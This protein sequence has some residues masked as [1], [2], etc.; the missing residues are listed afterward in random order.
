VAVG[1]ARAYSRAASIA[2]LRAELAALGIP[3]RVAAA[4]ADEAVRDAMRASRIARIYADRW[5]S[6][7]EADG[8]AEASRATVG[9]VRVIAATESAE[10]WNSGRLHALQNYPEIQVMRVWDATLDKRTCQVCANADGD[11]VGVQ[12]RFP[13]GEPGM[14]HPNCRCTWHPIPIQFTR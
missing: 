12:E 11:M 4:A 14:V 10:A 5:R 2:R 9:R 1:Q 13:N 8:A 7:A 3:K 6:V